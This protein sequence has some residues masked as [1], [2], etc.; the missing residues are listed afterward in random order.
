MSDKISMFPK[1][2]IPRLD[3]DIPVAEAVLEAVPGEVELDAVVKA[4]SSAPHIVERMVKL[5]DCIWSLAG[6][7]LLLP[8]EMRDRIGATEAVEQARLL[9]HQ[10]QVLDHNLELPEKK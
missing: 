3:E 9:L 7:L 8:K 1:A 10:S 5:E 2:H 4:Q 6:I